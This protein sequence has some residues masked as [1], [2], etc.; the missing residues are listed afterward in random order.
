EVM[1]RIAP[2]L[3]HHYGEMFHRA[4]LNLIKRGIVPPPFRLGEVGVWWHKGVEIDIVG[5]GESGELLFCEC[6]WEEGVDPERLSAWLREKAE[7]FLGARG[8]RDRRTLGRPEP[9]LH[10]YLFAKSFRG[11]AGGGSLEGLEGVRLFDLGDL[12]RLGL[13]SLGPGSAS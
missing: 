7:A 2:R 4:I 11:Y 6:K 8:G 3:S 5:R 10:F 9:R 1:S 12:G 13:S